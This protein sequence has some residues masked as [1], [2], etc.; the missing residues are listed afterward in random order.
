M[1]YS[2]LQAEGSKV[3]EIRESQCKGVST[4]LVM[5]DIA[6][7]PDCLNEMND[8][9]NRRFQYPFINCTNCGP[10]FTIIEDIPYDRQNTSMKSFE[11]C[12]E[13][14]AEYEDPGDRRYHAQPIACPVCGPNVA[15]WN[16]SGQELFMA[17]EAIFKASE[18]IK[19][20]FVLAVKGIGGFHL[21][22]DASNPDSIKRLRLRKHREEKP[23]ALMFPGIDSV[24]EECCVSEAEEMALLSIEAPIVL[25]KRRSR[26]AD[27]FIISLISDVVAPGNPYLGV[28]LPYSPLHHLLMQEIDKPLIAT[29][30]N[31]FDEPICTDEHEALAKLNNIADYF[32]VHNRPIVRHADDSIVRIIHGSCMII[33]RSRGFAPL[34]VR[35]QHRSCNRYIG[36]R[37]IHEEHDCSKEGRKYIHQSA[38]RRFVDKR[39]D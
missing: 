18:F 15:L 31:F 8:P 36:S 29:S 16:K 28:M 26:S 1:E 2:L 38:H 19:D 33:R 23:F 9:A 13:C 10:R 7:C 20:G 24:R 21:M 37:R 22:A 4:A 32:L 11:M 3:F 34:P 5:P 17:N 6:V 39:S 35:I 25:L 14:R 30:G 27:P 12:P